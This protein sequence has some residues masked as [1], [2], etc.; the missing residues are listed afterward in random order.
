METCYINSPLGVT[1]IEGDVDGII[2][3][4]VLNNNEL[5]E[6]NEGETD[7]LSFPQKWES[8]EKLTDIIPELLQDCVYQ[9]NEYFE[10][11]E[12]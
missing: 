10:G 1:K 6:T 8:N 2:S 7:S 5:A 9:L 4:S 3:I 11:K 12:F